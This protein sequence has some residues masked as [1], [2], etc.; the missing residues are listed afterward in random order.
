MYNAT[1]LQKI[2]RIFSNSATPKREKRR[3]RRKDE[4]KNH[5][6]KVTSYN[7]MLMGKKKR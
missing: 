7:S 1:S 2:L 3:R 4:K 6:E 5:S